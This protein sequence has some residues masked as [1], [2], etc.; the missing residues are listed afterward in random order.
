MKKFGLVLAKCIEQRQRKSHDCNTEK[1]TI[2]VT[3][4]IVRREGGAELNKL[5]NGVAGSVLAKCMKNT[6]DKYE[7]DIPRRIQRR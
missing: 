4:L 5:L 6:R 3:E 1:D 2:R 7:W